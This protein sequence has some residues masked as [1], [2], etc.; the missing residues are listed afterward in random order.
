VKLGALYAGECCLLPRVWKAAGTW[1]RMRGLLGRPPLQPGEGLWIEP[2]ASVHTL[3]M[4]YA[5]DLAFVDAQGRVKK[6]VHGISPLRLAGAVG[7]RATL[8]A[9]AGQLA[10][11]GLNVGDQI[12]WREQ[13]G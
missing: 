10:A 2:C 3:G 13:L 1:D 4:G 12:A 7:A 6:L 11:C 9:G 8:E 5:L